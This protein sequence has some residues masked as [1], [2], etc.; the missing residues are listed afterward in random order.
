MQQRSQ[1]E[2]RSLTGHVAEERQLTLKP[3]HWMR[4]SFGSLGQA[5][6]S[7]ECVETGI[8]AKR[9]NQGFHP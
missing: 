3:C 5:D 2:H 1:M 8:A 9:I 6:A 4:A 7:D